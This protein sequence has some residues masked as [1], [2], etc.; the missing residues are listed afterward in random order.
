MIKRYRDWM[1]KVDAAAFVAENAVLIG[2]NAVDTYWPA[3]R[4]AWR[5]GC[6]IP[7]GAVAARAAADLA[8]AS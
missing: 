2:D 4:R 6:S 5:A 3:H 8:G 1:P 7:P